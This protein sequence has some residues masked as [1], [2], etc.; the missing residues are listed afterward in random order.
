[1]TLELKQ[2]PATG[3]QEQSKHRGRLFGDTK[4]G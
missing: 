2:G 3:H 4:V 1:L